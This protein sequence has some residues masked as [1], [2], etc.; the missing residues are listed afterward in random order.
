MMFPN[1]SFSPSSIAAL[2]SSNDLALYDVLFS[3]L[4]FRNAL[5]GFIQENN[6]S[7]SHAKPH[8]I[9]AV[10]ASEVYSWVRPQEHDIKSF[11]FGGLIDNFE[12]L[13]RDE[14]LNHSNITMEQLF[15]HT[16]NNFIIFDKHAEECNSLFQMIQNKI[17]EV[18]EINKRVLENNS[19]KDIEFLYTKMNSI[20]SDHN[21]ITSQEADNIEEIISL[22][23]S[24]FGELYLDHAKVANRAKIFIRQA[25]YV[26]IFNRNKLFF[27]TPY[28]KKFNK[29]ISHAKYERFLETENTQYKIYTIKHEMRV[30]LNKIT[31][32]DHRPKRQLDAAIER[33]LE[34]LAQAQCVNDFLFLYQI[35][36]KIEFVTRSSR[37]HLASLMLPPETL[38]VPIRHPMF[39][40]GVH[41][42]HPSI[43]QNLSEIS[44]EVDHSV[45]TLLRLQVKDGT[46]YFSPK[47]TEEVTFLNDQIKELA[48]SAISQMTS[49]V[50]S[51]RTSQKLNNEQ[52]S[53]KSIVKRVSDMLLDDFRLDFGQFEKKITDQ[54]SS[55]LMSS[56]GFFKSTTMSP[57]RNI[58][59][60][61]FKNKKL[62]VFIN[63]VSVNPF[64]VSNDSFQSSQ[65][66][67]SF[68]IINSN[69]PRLFFCHGDVFQTW[70]EKNRK[71]YGIRKKIENPT[72]IIIEAEALFELAVKETKKKYHGNISFPDVDILESVLIQAILYASLGWYSVAASVISPF[73]KYVTSEIKKK[74]PSNFG[75]QSEV[76][77]ETTDPR[78]AL[79][80]K[81]LFLLR[82]YCERAANREQNKNIS[83]PIVDTPAGGN[84]KNISRAQRDL[85]LSVYM[86]EEYIR[87]LRIKDRD[88]NK[89]PNLGSIAKIRQNQRFAFD[90]R[91]N[92]IHTASWLEMFVTQQINKHSLR[93]LKLQNITD[94]YASDEQPAERPHS[95]N[96]D[97][98][99]SSQS[100]FTEFQN[101]Y[102]TWMSAGI[103]KQLEIEIKRI[104]QE[105]KALANNFNLPREE[106]LWGYLE[107]HGMSILSM[108]FISS[109]LF[110]SHAGIRTIWNPWIKISY[111]QF[112]VF[113]NWN[114]WF[115]QFEQLES[116]FE[117]EIR[118]LKFIKLFSS[119]FKNINTIRTRIHKSNL[120][121]T[122]DASDIYISFLEEV[123]V[124]EQAVIDYFKNEFN[125]EQS[126]AP[127]GLIRKLKP[128]ILLK[129]Q[130]IKSEI[131]LESNQ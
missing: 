60:K 23:G 31:S 116:K 54:I 73:T 85:D 100:Q 86:S 103:I 58:H 17:I 6:P 99:S 26:S 18:E 130:E 55:N 115:N 107:A 77:K 128:F 52:Q 71:E 89:T 93:L 40:P 61:L 65:K 72:K 91:L 92:L 8:I 7:I 122:R 1:N 80:F 124:F 102:E 75:G 3:K 13:G 30:L 15:F 16:K 48:T 34:T 125:I 94:A 37:L 101:R 105:R 68:R 22:W 38:R 112:L 106:R 78:I 87:L 28:L 2:I 4:V 49:V 21:L 35:P 36:V 127:E 59:A 67:T 98:I 9:Y 110:D 25:K 24:N 44:Q 81:E 45:A 42:L 69:L 118:T 83:I 74:T 51:N 126:K 64:L 66:M 129:I 88:N 19:E 53:L 12:T 131:R 41:N 114:D 119:I 97:C 32:G 109:T 95:F 96:Y 108:S 47:E 84:I 111:E 46:S 104:T 33:D 82:H 63:S 27:E 50:I 121:N 14:L 113:R 62:E 20:L 56:I 29:S 39:I 90:L 79:A 123:N 43:L 57:Q 120:R 11:S 10:D 117:F 5:H 76:F 70:L